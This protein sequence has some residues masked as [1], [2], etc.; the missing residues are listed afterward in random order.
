MPTVLV[1]PVVD[2]ALAPAFRRHRLGLRLW[3]LG[4]ACTVAPDLDTIGYFLGVPYGG[5]LWYAGG[6]RRKEP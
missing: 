4:A 5:V 1:H 2:L 3:A 6:K